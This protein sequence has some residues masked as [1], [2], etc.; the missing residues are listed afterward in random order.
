MASR[1]VG[2]SKLVFRLLSPDLPFHSSHSVEFV[3]RAGYTGWRGLDCFFQ[4]A[5]GKIC[6]LAITSMVR[7]CGTTE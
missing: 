1:P 6:G 4:Q 3:A 2:D 5:A 7:M